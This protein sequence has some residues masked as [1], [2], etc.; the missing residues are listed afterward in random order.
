M[1]YDRTVLAYHGCDA[2]TAEHL[3]AGDPFKPS[4]NDFD[5]LGQG[6][7]FWE[8]GPDRALRFA[9]DQQRRASPWS[10]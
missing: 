4:V 10:A 5:W 9:E 2:E 8:H 7:Y 3:L 1:R 6:I